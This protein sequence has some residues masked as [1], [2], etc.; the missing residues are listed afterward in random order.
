MVNEKRDAQIPFHGFMF[1]FNS[2]HVSS[3]S[4]SS[5]RTML[6]LNFQDR[7]ESIFI[8]KYVSSILFKRYSGFKMF[9]NNI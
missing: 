2:L 5:S 9:V 8:A 7:N 4:C 6:S 1:I 3:T